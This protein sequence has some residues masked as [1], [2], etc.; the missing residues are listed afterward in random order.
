MLRARH[1]AQHSHLTADVHTGSEVTAASSATIANEGGRLFLLSREELAP[2]TIARS[3]LLTTLCA[4]TNQ[5][6]LLPLDQTAFRAWAASASGSS[7]STLV[8]ESGVALPPPR[9]FID[10]LERMKVRLY[11]ST[12]REL[13]AAVPSRHHS[14]CVSTQ[15]CLLNRY[16]QP[17]S[18]SR[19]SHTK[20]L[21]S[22]VCRHDQ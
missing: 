20:L 12:S 7:L 13:C 15:L 11:V 18:A 9:S 14:V 1:S 17:C 19:S 8:S 21:W 6:A 22:F 5:N 10:M 4:A 16:E 3:A 2:D